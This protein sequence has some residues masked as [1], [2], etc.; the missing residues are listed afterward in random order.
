MIWGTMVVVII[1]Y[2]LWAAFPFIYAFIRSFTKWSPLK[3]DFNFIG[4]ANYREA[5]FNDTLFWPAMGK[6]AYFSAANVIIGTA[7]C[8]AV[9]L[10]VNSVKRFRGFFRFAY[11]LPVP[12]GMV[13]VAIVWQFI[14]QTRFGI[15]NH[16]IFSMARALRFSSPPEIGWLTRP[17][18]AMPSIIMLTWWKWLGYRMVIFMA[19]L[20]GIPD[21]FYE[22]A[23]IDGAGRWAQF[24]HITLPLLTP[25]VLLTLVHSTISS[26][27]VF[28]QIQVM[29]GGGPMNATRTIMMHLYDRT[30]GLYRFGYGAALSFIMFVIILSLTAFELKVLRTRWEY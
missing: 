6:T 22:A 12:L 8:L 16:I 9:A 26:I 24:R 7:L 17:Q 27:Q 29:T 19:G 5:L 15:L 25:S 3:F 21:E 30:F 2:T 18:W 4:L 20:Q 28:A 11:F 10:M 23:Q 13:S 14:L 1:H